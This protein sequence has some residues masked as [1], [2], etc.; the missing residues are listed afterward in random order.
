M[1]PFLGLVWPREGQLWLAAWGCGSAM[2][3]TVGDQRELQ[4]EKLEGDE[5]R[6]RVGDAHHGSE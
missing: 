6:V 1:N 3:L 4:G 2:G 5:G